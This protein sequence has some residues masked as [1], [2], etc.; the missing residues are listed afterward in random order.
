MNNRHFSAF[1]LLG[2]LLFLLLGGSQSLC[3]AEPAKGSIFP[4]LSG[5]T[6]GELS[7]YGPDT[8]Y[9]P[10][11]GAADMFLRYNFE[12]MQS[13]EY[14]K[15]SDSFSVEAYRHATPLDAFGP[16]CQNRPAKDI[17][18]DLGVQG[19]TDS[20]VLIFLAGRHYIEIR[21]QGTSQECR[22]AMM[23]IAKSMAAALND[24][25]KFPGFFSVFPSAGKKPWSEK[26]LAQDILGYTFL[27]HAFRVDYEREGKAFSLFAMRGKDAAEAADMLKAYRRQLKLAEE[28]VAEGYLEISDPY[29]GRLALWKSGRFLLCY[30]GGLSLEEGRK[31][32]GELEKQI[33]TFKE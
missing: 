26:Y 8:L 10:I 9:Q 29:H 5:W 1:H 3:A 11:D 30:Q 16:Y 13:L 27:K 6:K 4:E 23:S 7:S 2:A 22:S 25:A 15:G 19:Y 33:Q 21:T 20:E 12:E 32:L 17:Y 31:L 28:P 24:G 14:T 18:I